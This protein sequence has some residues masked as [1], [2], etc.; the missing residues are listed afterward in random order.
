RRDEINQ[1]VFEIL[2]LVQLQDFARRKPNQLSGGQKQRVA[3]ARA[4]IKKPKVLL[5]DEPLAAL[6]KKLREETQFE[7]VNIQETLGVTFIVVTHDQEEAMTLS[8]RIGVMNAGEIVQIGEPREIYEYPG[9][10]FVADF[11]GS[12]NVFEGQVVEED[13]DFVIIRSVEAKA[14]IFVSHGVSCTPNQKVAYAIRPEK[15]R[16]SLQKPKQAKNLLPGTVEE[17]AYMGNLSVYQ[18]KLATGKIVRVT[19][20][21]LIRT[22]QNAITWEDK[23]FLTWDGAAGVVL[24]S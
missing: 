15:I 24:T 4:L 12:V 7:L 21:N 10:R 1:L 19:Q 18:V 17:I 3:L 9:S 8:T 16:M 20:P 6:D 5:L 23:V 14:D 2:T 13:T 11:I 22:D